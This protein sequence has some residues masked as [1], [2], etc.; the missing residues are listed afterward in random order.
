[1]SG[2]RWGSNLAAIIN[3]TLTSLGQADLK[4]AMGTGLLTAGSLVWPLA[5][6]HW[7]A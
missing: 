1:M 3:Q 4:T 2:Q 7:P 5:M 6:L